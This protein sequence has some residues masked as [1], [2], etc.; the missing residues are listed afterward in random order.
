MSLYDPDRAADVAP[1]QAIVIAH[2]FVSFCKRWGET[3]GLP[4]ALQRFGEDPTPERAAKLH[5]WASFSQFLDHTLRE[6][7]DGTLDAWFTDPD[8]VSSA[9]ARPPSAR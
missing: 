3:H 1:D 7:E 9:R 4:G 8:G 2:R 6:L 5:A